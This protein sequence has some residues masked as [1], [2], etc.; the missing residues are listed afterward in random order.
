MPRI[1]PITTNEPKVLMATRVETALLARVHN[2]AAA[3]NLTIRE[4]VEASLRA[5]LK[6]K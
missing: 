6:R 3:N 4:V 5:Y 2:Y 1:Q